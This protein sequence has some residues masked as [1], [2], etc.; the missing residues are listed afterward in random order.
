MQHDKSLYLGHR[1]DQWTD[2]EM[3]QSL[4]SHVVLTDQVTFVQAGSVYS[5]WECFRQLFRLA[6]ALQDTA[7]WKM[8]PFEHF[9][10]KEVWQFLLLAGCSPFFQLEKFKSSTSGQDNWLLHPFQPKVRGHRGKRCS[11]KTWR[12][13]AKELYQQL[14]DWVRPG[15]VAACLT[16]GPLL[17]TLL[18]VYWRQ[19]A[20]HLISF[21]LLSAASSKEQTVFLPRLTGGQQA[22]IACC[23]CRSEMCAPE[24]GRQCGAGIMFSYPVPIA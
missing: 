4:T 10:Q 1:I 20:L 8:V 6:D 22:S 18:N 7:C 3:V 9:K 2:D 14:P 16:F 21:G 12:G 11:D 19:L 17:S 24:H 13:K 5:V 23:L 15:S